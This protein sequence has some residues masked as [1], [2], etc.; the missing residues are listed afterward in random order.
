M[1]RYLG[2]ACHRSRELGLEWQSL[3]RYTAEV[4][5]EELAASGSRSQVTR[6]ELGRLMKENKDLRETCLFLDQSRARDGGMAETTSLT[7]PEA[8]EIL[9]HGRI[10]GA[11]NRVQGEVPRYTGSTQHTTL[12]D[13]EAIRVGVM[14]ERNKEMALTEMN[15]RLHRLEMERLELVKV[16]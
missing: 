2:E 8:I 10:A 7:P 16:S 5:K 13:S 11:I 12:K 1:C 9:L 15:K 14:S 4:L 3:G 6:E